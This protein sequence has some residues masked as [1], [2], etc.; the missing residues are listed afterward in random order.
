MT[1]IVF[2]AEVAVPVEVAGLAVV[3]VTL[4]VVVTVMEA[5]AV[6]PLDVDSLTVLFI[7]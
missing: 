1:R 7:K 6:I 4:V 5:T 2:V 3:L